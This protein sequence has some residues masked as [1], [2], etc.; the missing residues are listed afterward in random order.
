MSQ[1]KWPDYSWNAWDEG[2]QHYCV[3]GN[4]F[5]GYYAP[6]ILDLRPVLEP[7][8]ET[9]Q[10]YDGRRC[11]LEEHG[12]EIDDLAGIT[13]VLTQ[14]V[15]IKGWGRDQQVSLANQVA[16][17]QALFQASNYTVYLDIRQQ[18]NRM[19]LYYLCRTHHDYWGEYSLIVEDYHLSPRYPLL[20]ERFAK[21]MHFGHEVYYLRLSPFRKAAAA[22]L[23]PGHFASSRALD[24][25]L[26]TAGRNVF[27][28]AWHEDQRLAVVVANHFGL[29]HFRQAIE[30]LYLCL[31]GEL[32]DLRRAVN[33][34]LL[35]FF[36]EVYPQPAIQA[37]LRQL[38]RL[39][40]S[41]I[42]D[43]P[44]QALKL[45]PRLSRAFSDFLEKEVA[46]GRQQARVPLYKI[47]YGNFS[48]LGFIVSELQEKLNLQEEKETL[49]NES[50]AII[51]DLL[52]LV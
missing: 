49:E 45:Y 24:H 11:Q 42:N 4:V 20:D 32:C 28:A 22:I 15:T 52:S 1:T 46:W 36:G 19:P 48:R 51:D 27:Q 3:G 6:P 31:S 43:L 7:L 2:S 33:D 10:E 5:P 17:Q 29:T 14:K 23:A 41:I 40:G 8:L 21:F 12:G 34:Q 38:P 18:E 44:Q 13:E 35:R 26:Y 47:I 30:L 37:F 50:Q 16:L 9:L 39:E 25:L